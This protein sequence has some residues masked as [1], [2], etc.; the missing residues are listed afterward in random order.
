VSLSTV[1]GEALSAGLKL[2]TA[3]GR[4]EDIIENYKK[5]FAGFSEQELDILDGIILQPEG[6]Q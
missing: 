4:S 6:R 5:A 2:Q 3:T 1:I